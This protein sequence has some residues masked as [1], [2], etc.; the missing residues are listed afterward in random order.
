MKIPKDA[1]IWRD[2]CD[3]DLFHVGCKLTMRR[4]CQ[5]FS[6]SLV[7]IGYVFGDEAQKQAGKLKPGVPV[8]LKD[9]FDAPGNDTKKKVDTAGEDGR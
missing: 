8:P 4:Q 7:G 6:L 5:W 2:G 9:V 3:R 1:R